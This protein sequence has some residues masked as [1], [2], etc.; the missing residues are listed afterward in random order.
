MIRSG[1]G[2]SSDLFS[3]LT[4]ALDASNGASYETSVAVLRSLGAEVLSFHDQPN[5]ININEDCGCT[6]PQVIEALVSETGADVGISHDGDADRVLLCDE[7]GSVLDGDEIMAIAA[8]GLL[9]KGLLAKNTLVAT[10]MSNAGLEEA[11]QKAG[12]QVVRAGVGDRYVME[13]MKEHGYNL[14]GEQSGHFI[15]RDHN[16]T[17]DGIV[18][19]LQL[20]QIMKEKG[21]PLSELRRL[22]TKFPQVQRNV[23]VSAKPDLESLASASLIAEIRDAL[24][25]A[26]RVMLRYS[27]TEPLL[28]ILIEG[29]DAEWI[30]AQADRLAEAIGAEIG[31]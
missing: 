31:A 15:F 26:G 22:L 5:G 11:V 23:R 30:G 16:T 2:G 21:K 24:G 17:G 6:H 10:V 19:A 20:L 3:G 9:E 18:S 8:V 25:E 4:I 7:K 12:G 29:K 14:G 13:A 27:G 1:I 28:R